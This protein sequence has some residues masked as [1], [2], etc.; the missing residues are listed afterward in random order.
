[1]WVKRPITARM[2]FS[3]SGE[4]KNNF[5]MYNNEKASFPNPPRL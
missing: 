2:F 4:K 3:I 5:H 1:M